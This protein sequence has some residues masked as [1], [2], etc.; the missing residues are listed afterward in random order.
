MV[1]YLITGCGG[2]V[3]C[4]Y[5]SFLKE[6]RCT[7]DVLG[8]GTTAPE[9][10]DHKGLP[11]HFERVNLLDDVR[12][13]KL[14]K[15]YQPRFC[16]HL[17]SMSS[18]GDSWQQPAQSFVNNTNI[19]LNLVDGVRKYSPKTRVLSVG[20]SEQYGRINSRTLSLT[21]SDVLDP[22]SPYA[23]SR[24]A[25][26][27]LAKTY[28]SGYGLD[29]VMTRSFNH[30]GY[31]QDSRFALSSFARRFGVGVARQRS[32]IT[33]NV[34]NL[35]VVRD[36][37]DVRDVVRA[38]DLIVREARVGSI[39]NVC[40]G[41]GIALVDAV[42]YLSNASGLRYHAQLDQ[43]LFRPLEQSMVI[44][45]HEAIT[46]EL[47]WNPSFTFEESLDTLLSYW[48]LSEGK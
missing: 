45:S 8:I 28:V 15:K 39:F 2:F 19:F 1:E 9:K 34:G 40:S 41:R 23:V 37:V 43:T 25:Q 31:G 13:S 10:R 7:G 6:K 48:I 21:E 26:E 32:E 30:V 24:C 14:L 4:H 36:F 20:S 16:I 35:Q 42:D 27:Q 11:F 47:G 5:L 44:G 22:T 29:I 38:Y 3:G 17:A 33:L 18:V 46:A 12:L